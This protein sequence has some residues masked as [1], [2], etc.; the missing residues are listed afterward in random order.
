MQEMANLWWNIT[1]HNFCVGNVNAGDGKSLVEYNE[2]QFCVGNVN[3]G[4]GKSLV[5]Y[6]EA[7]FC[8]GVNAGDGKSVW[9]N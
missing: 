5:E 9:W 8:V 4:D 2:A 6:N 1:R 7:Q 3:A